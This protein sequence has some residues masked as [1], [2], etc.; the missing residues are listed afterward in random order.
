M[1]L[2]ELSFSM[3]TYMSCIML[4]KNQNKRN[5]SSRNTGMAERISS[6]TNYRKDK[7]RI[8]NYM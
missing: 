6:I 3:I 8:V 4:P 7:T 5:N 1:L 2:T